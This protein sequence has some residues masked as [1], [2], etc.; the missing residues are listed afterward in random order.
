MFKRK[1][2]SAFT[3]RPTVSDYEGDEIV[4][5]RENIGHLAIINGYCYLYSN[6]SDEASWKL[7]VL[8]YERARKFLNER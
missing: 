4:I 2:D 5:A 1:K 8:D 3:F 6:Y 7:N